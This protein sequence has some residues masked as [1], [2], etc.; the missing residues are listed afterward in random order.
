MGEKG[1]GEEEKVWCGEE[2]GGMVVEVRMGGQDIYS[3]S[4]KTVCQGCTDQ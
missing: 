2:E 4:H 3:S 1:V